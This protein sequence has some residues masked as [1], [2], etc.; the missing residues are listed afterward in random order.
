MSLQENREKEQIAIR[1]VLSIVR[2]TNTQREQQTAMERWVLG[3]VTETLL[4]N[5]ET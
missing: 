3:A 1:K 4:V 2:G 5:E